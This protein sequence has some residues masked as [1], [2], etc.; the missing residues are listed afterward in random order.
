MKRIFATSL[1]LAL[2]FIKGLSAQTKTRNFK[3]FVGSDIKGFVLQPVSSLGDRNLKYNFTP[4]GSLTAVLK[5]NF[6]GELQLGYQVYK[7]DGYDSN[8]EDF[9]T[10]GL[11]SKLII[12]VQ[13]TNNLIRGGIGFFTSFYKQQGQVTLG[14]NY[15]E[16]AI[17]PFENSYNLSG[18]LYTLGVN[19]PLKGDRL[20][21][22]LDINLYFINWNSDPVTDSALDRPLLVP[23]IGRSGQF[24]DSYAAMNFGLLLRY[25]LGAIEADR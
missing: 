7:S 9:S 16:P 15:F 17:F 3:W 4:N 19:V 1:I 13:T 25:R 11:Y 5:R 10:N 12:G 8:L 2:V 20:L 14:E 23:G 21:L 18:V 24:S 22:G 6:F